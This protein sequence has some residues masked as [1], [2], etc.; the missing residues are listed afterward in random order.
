MSLG[1]SA[2][3][4]I[5]LLGCRPESKITDDSIAILEDNGEALDSNI[6]GLQLTTSAVAKICYCDTN[7]CNDGNSDGFKIACSGYVVTLMGSFGIV[8]NLIA[9]TILF[10][11]EMK[12]STNYILIGKMPVIF[13]EQLNSYF[14]KRTRAFLLRILKEFCCHLQNV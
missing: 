14:E 6:G 13:T 3:A 2:T 1:C 10:R 8:G 7:G 11:P 4:E 12:S 5:Q 9:I